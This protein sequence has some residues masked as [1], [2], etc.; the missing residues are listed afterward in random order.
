MTRF[1]LV[2]SMWQGLID[3]H[4]KTPMGVT[5]EN[6]AEKYKIRRDECDLFALRS[7]AR[8]KIAHDDGRFNIEMAPITVKTKKGISSFYRIVLPKL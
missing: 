8:W 2:D 7:Q 6:L 4:V 5:A 1:Q 3:H